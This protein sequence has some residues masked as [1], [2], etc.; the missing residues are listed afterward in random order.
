MIG[1]LTGTLV[2][3][4]VTTTGAVTALQ[5]P[6]AAATTASSATVQYW[7]ET[8]LQVF[9]QQG[10][11]PGPLSRGAAMMHGAIFDVLNSADWGRKSYVGTGF[12]HAFVMADT[13]TTVNDDLAAGIAA[14]DVL[15]DAFPAQSA[16]I[17]QRYAGRHGTTAQADATALAGQVVAAVR[18][19]RVNDGASASQAYT[20]GTEAGAW[21]LNEG[22][23]TRAVDP[24]WGRVRPFVMTSGSQN[25]NPL[26]GG[27]T[28]YS[29]L[30]S[31][32]VY[33]QNFNDVKSLGK[34]DSTTRTPDQT[35]AAFYW[36][37][38]ANGTY[39]PPG[40]LLSH[41]WAIAQPRITSPLQLSQL[42]TR[43]SFAVADATISA[44]NHKYDTPVDLWRPISAI[45]RA[46]EDNNTAT[47]PDAGWQPL[48]ATPCFP[49]WTSGHATLAG[50]WAEVIKKQFGDAIT[51]TGDT[52][53][54]SSPVRNR[55]FTSI[56]QAAQENADSRVWLGVHFRFDSGDGL[57]AGTKAGTLAAGKLTGYKCFDPCI[58]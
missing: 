3:M 36:A 41:T 50:A 10:G 4:A 39:K 22:A 31:S 34:S 45:R 32:S 48:G 42:F 29:T 14:R 9:R 55:T 8:A 5:Q 54:P 53:D 30:L 19:N 47:E 58:G 16:Y 57:T 43:V 17:N 27:A 7:N 28:N 1:R 21:Q 38:D 44:W 52:D 46:G 15:I 20:V 13:S 6:A 11:G 24:H 51:F 25:R 33:T 37:N 12:R 18:A 56:S 35:V 26:P 49:A 40:Q 23:C 2:A